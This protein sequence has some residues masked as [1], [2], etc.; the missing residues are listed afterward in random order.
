MRMMI[1]DLFVVD[2][3]D[4]EVLRL[5]KKKVRCK[6]QHYEI[7]HFLKKNGRGSSGSLD[8]PACICLKRWSVQDQLRRTDASK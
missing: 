2:N 5:L 6:F 7:T 4:F 1:K 8:F 3:D